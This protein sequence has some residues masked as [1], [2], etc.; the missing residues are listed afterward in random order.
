MKRLVST[1]LSVLLLIC[2]LP[3]EAMAANDPQYSGINISDV[4]T[5]NVLITASV[6]NPSRFKLTEGGFF[7]GKTAIN[8]HSM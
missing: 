8:L 1:V 6:D 2:L 7:F 5:D 4:T 3:V